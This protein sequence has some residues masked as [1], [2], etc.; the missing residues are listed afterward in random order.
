MT[1]RRMYITG[2][3]GSSGFRERF[4]TDYD[5]PNST[6][7]SETCAS[8]GVMMF[9]QRMAAITG[10]ASYYDYVEKAL[11]N[12]VI[13]GINIAGDRYFYVNPLEVVPEFCTEHTYMEH[14]KPV[15]QK[16]F[17]VACCPPNVGRTLA[18]L[19]Q[20][21]Y[22]EDEYGV[23]INQFISSTADTEVR[24]SRLKIKM[25]STLLQDGKVQIEVQS[26]DQEI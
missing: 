19:G 4:T 2:G 10:D 17:G 26:S 7:Y 5:L 3:I 8:I 11:Y 25:N 24:E 21:I 22:A 13:A 14:V 16:W 6:N 9:G 1:D 18:S 15:R 23:Y 20:Y 12:T